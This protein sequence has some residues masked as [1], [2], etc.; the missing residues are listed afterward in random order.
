MNGDYIRNASHFERDIN[1]SWLIDVNLIARRNELLKTLLLDRY[2]IGAHL[3]RIEYIVTA[4]AR[5]SIERNLGGFIRE[6]HRS[7]RYG[8]AG[9]IKHRTGNA[10]RSALTHRQGKN[11][12]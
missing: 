10:G 4:T 12:K 8:R 3:D 6:S 7:A 2:G 1:R 9:L 11:Y 5:I